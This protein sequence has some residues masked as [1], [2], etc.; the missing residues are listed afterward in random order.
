MHLK[1]QPTSPILNILN[2]VLATANTMVLNKRDLE[3]AFSPKLKPR[4]VFRNGAENFG[5]KASSGTS[6]NIKVFVRV[7]PFSNQ[8]ILQNQR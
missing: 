3:R 1:L 6:S 2:I 4:K 5:P 8:E 7:R